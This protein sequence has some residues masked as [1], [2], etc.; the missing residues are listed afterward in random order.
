MASFK[1]YLKRPKDKQPTA[2]YFTLSYGAFEIVNGRKRYLPLKYYTSEQ[3]EPK[4]WNGKEGKVRDS[5]VYREAP[6]FNSRLQYVKTQTLEVL[7]KLQNDNVT[8]T[9]DLLKDEL[10]ILFKK[11]RDQ[12]EKGLNLI[13]FIERF[14]DASDRAE[15]TKKSYRRVL[16]D[17][18]E[19]Q[20]EYKRSLSYDD[21]DLDFHTDFINLL[22]AK[23][24][25]TNT[26]GT[27]IKVLKTFMNE[28]YERGLHS[29]L[30][31]KKKLFSKPS[32][33]S[34]SIYLGINEL[35]RLH[36]LDLSKNRRLE[37]VR[38]WFL[39]ASYTGLRYSDLKRLTDKNF[40]DSSIEIKTQ[41]TDT[42]VVIPLTPIVKL[43]LEKY[44]YELPK[45]ASNQKFNDYIKEVCKLAEI[46]ES[47]REEQVK[48]GMKKIEHVPKYKLVTMHTARRSFATNAY[49]KGVPAMRI[50]MMTGHRTEKSF[51]KYIKISEKENAKQL[52]MH[53]FFSQMV[54]NG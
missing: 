30:D 17:L 1:F 42:N 9:N 24:Y 50:M 27:R 40:S 16:R 8:I 33:E 26:I 23:D 52:M 41:K 48:G 15:G 12:T 3:I 6:E 22:K 38:D 51:M 44:E 54:V 11:D 5:G 19:F 49:I 25:K 31:F 10:D 53:P 37:S 45:L 18:E 2:I 34:I 14:I 13:Q 36:T 20:Y 29:N 35:K 7:R 43:I 28:A 39:I 47:V 32:E 21:I 4:Y 46:N